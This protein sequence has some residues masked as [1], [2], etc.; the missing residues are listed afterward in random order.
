MNS[1]TKTPQQLAGLGGTPAT[2]YGA[3]VLHIYWETTP[4]AVKRVLPP[5]LEP[6]PVPLVNAFIANYPKTSF[7]PPYQEAGL[8]VLARHGEEFGLYCLSMPIT[9]G[10]AMAMGRENC[11]LPKK[12]ADIAFDL[13]GND[14]HG[15]IAR[16]GVTFFNLNAQIGNPMNSPDAKEVLNRTVGGGIPMFNVKYSKAIDGSG[17]DLPPTLVS[18]LLTYH[19]VESHPVHCTVEMQ[20]SPHDPWAEMEIVRMLG[21]HYVVGDNVLEKGKVLATVPPM[22]FAPYAWLRW[23]WW[24]Q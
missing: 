14:F 16:N 1:F 15:S 20:D 13:N 11:G 8:F 24:A 22:E 23:D 2:F 18:Q 4:E 7:C 21:G 19:T 5:G 10:M 12:M 17:F 6:G 3:Q 9:D